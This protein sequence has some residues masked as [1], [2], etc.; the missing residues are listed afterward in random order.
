M[1]GIH[2]LGVCTSPNS[3]ALVEHM[4]AIHP[5]FS[6]DIQAQRITVDIGCAAVLLQHYS[7][8]AL[9]SEFS[10]SRC[11]LNYSIASIPMDGRDRI[12]GK[13]NAK[14]VVGKASEIRNVRSW[15]RNPG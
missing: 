12:I 13:L 5:S 11:P 6:C 8:F 3:T 15:V 10:K 4:S 14:D 2:F 9:G 7:R 1:A